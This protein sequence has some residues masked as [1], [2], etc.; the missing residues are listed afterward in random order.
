MTNSEKAK[1]IVKIIAGTLSQ[2]RATTVQYHSQ[3]AAAETGKRE[4]EA[5][6]DDEIGFG[7]RSPYNPDNAR[8][9][10]VNQKAI[11]A[12]WE[13]IYEYA[14]DVFLSKLDEP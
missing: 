9:L 2:V 8:Q 11:Q 6:H 5:A 4:W 7:S 12:E 3:L 13:E 10:L 14:I 1:S